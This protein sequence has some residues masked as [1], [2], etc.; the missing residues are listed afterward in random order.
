VTASPS[1]DIHQALRA[2]ARDAG[3][4]LG[5][6]SSGPE[7]SVVLVHADGVL[8]RQPPAA[9]LP[10]ESLVAGIAELLQSAGLSAR[11]LGGLVV[12][13][14]PGSF[15]GLRVGLATIK[16]LALG[17]G[18]PIFGV[19]SLEVLAAAAGPGYVVAARDARRGQLYAGLYL[20]DAAGT[21][22]RVLADGAWSLADLTR[23]V[24]HAL[25]RHA[26]LGARGAADAVRVVGD[27]A[28]ALAAAWGVPEVPATPPRM[29]LGILA[30][31]VAIRAGASEPLAALVPRYM[32]LTEAQAR[33]LAS[34]AEGA[35]G[36]SAP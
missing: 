16:G 4:L 32:R 35:A 24:Q 20:V 1:P 7:A 13:L 15:T 14:G 30:A 9:S 28:S 12:G 19:S 36:P 34:E 8:E 27:A 2:L 10:S 18:A 29:A 22:Q 21:A 3:P 11:A 17:T 33:L 26:T 6:D 5:L 31:Q 25:P 23:S